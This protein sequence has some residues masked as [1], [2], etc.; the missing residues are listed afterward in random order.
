M[1]DRVAFEARGVTDDGY[2]NTEGAFSTEFEVA[3]KIVARLGGETVLAARLSGRQPVTITVYQSSE[4]RRITTDW[5]AR[6]V[7][8]DEIYNIR[9][10]AD[11]D[12]GRGEVFDLLCEPGVA[13]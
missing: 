2:G 4:T 11:P 12:A 8:T 13:T 1:R 3:A 9:S 5:R 6:N 7:R 10:I